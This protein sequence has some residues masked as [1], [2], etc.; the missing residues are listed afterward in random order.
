MA[1]A[2]FAPVSPAG[3]RL[4]TCGNGS[5]FISPLAGRGLVVSFFAS[6]S[7]VVS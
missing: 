3:H 4:H 7:I 2:A 1:M 6:L 5:A